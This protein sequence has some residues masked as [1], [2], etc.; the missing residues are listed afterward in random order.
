MACRDGASLLRRKNMVCSAESVHRIGPVEGP[1]SEV[2]RVGSR[3]GVYEV[4]DCIGQGAMG[5]VYR[6]E[7]SLLRK[8]VALKVMA[9]SARQAPGGHHRFIR[10]A[11]AAAATKHPHVVDILDIGVLDGT[12]FIV[13]EFLEGVD[14]ETYLK[15][16]GMLNDQELADLALPIIAAIGAVHDAGVIHRDIK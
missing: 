1:A 14:L 16:R 2:L 6:A 7:H 3:F 5:Q 13:M 12:P 8:T 4:Q 10:E 15:R 11:R 9:K